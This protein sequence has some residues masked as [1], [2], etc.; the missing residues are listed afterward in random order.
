[1]L[2]EAAS[3][4]SPSSSPQRARLGFRDGARGAHAS[5]TMMLAELDQLLAHAPSDASRE[6]YRALILDENVLGKK[7]ASN[8]EKANRYLGE[9]Y[10]LDP[11]AATFRVM[12]QLWSANASARPLL[13]LLCAASRDPLLRGALPALLEIKDGQPIEL[14]VIRSSLDP[15]AERF[16]AASLHSMSQNIAS[17]LAQAGYA[18]GKL[19]KVRRRAMATPEAAAFAVALGW[20]EGARG[21][22]LLATFWARCLDRNPAEVMELVAAAGRAGLLEVRVAGVVVE[23]RP[24]GLLTPTELESP[25]GELA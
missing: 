25:D 16:S 21:R 3:P 9:L 11:R 14:D 10:G 8:R 23:I 5:R 19:R 22:A 18:Q 17:T 20:L 13:A 1:M 6:H 24:Q 4:Q 2:V 12:R 7:T 15:V